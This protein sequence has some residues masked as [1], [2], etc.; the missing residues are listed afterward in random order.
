MEGY[1]MIVKNLLLWYG[2]REEIKE[3]GIPR[4]AL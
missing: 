3:C 1:L 2:K 4:E